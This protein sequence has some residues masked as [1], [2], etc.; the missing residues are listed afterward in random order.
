MR[1]ALGVAAVLAMI[2]VVG[3]RAA[4]AADDEAPPCLADVQQFC[5][6]VPPTG[7]FEQGCLQAHRDQLSADCRKRVDTYTTDN[8]ALSSACGSDARRYC[9]N[10]QTA[11]GA[12]QSCLVTH[13][14]SLSEKCREKLDE[15]SKR[16]STGPTP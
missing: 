6:N 8:E 4:W 11:A 10:I 5:A 1:S 12:Q 14:E 3:A 7:N 15:Q 2:V 13:R 9:E 16:E